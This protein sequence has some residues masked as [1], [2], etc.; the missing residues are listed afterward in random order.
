MIRPW[1]KRLRD[2]VG[3]DAAART[4]QEAERRFREI[5]EHAPIGM[6]VTTL[7]GQ[8]VQVN[9]AACQM[10]GYH[11]DELLGRS[12]VDV[13]H[14]DDVPRT[15]RGLAA[16][17]L[18]EGGTLAYD[19][20]YVHRDGRTLWVSVNAAVMRDE[21]GRAAF[22]VG[23]IKDITERVELEHR[24]EAQRAELER[25]NEELAQFASVASHDLREPLRVIAGYLDLLVRRFGDALDEEARELVRE[26]VGGAERM[27]ELIDG[28][29]RYS[30]VGRAQAE[31]REV[32]VAE[33]LDGTLQG[34]QA[35]LRDAEA[36]VEVDE[37][38]PI[39]QADPALL[40]QLFQ[41]LLA[42]AVKFRNGSP[43]RVRV[44]GETLA[45][46]WRFVVEDNGIGVPPEAAERI[47]DMFSRATTRDRYEGT[48][49]GLAVC[50][51]IV[52]RHNGTIGVEPVADGPGSRF[53]FTIP[54][55]GPDAAAPR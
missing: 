40:G 22:V 50:R 26:A 16:F 48:G 49:I 51:R 36:T 29:L 39:V 45:D 30:G 46:G 38:L 4:L 47:F 27:G 21:D 28:L 20:R 15:L 31:R 41:N 54:A 33:I 12:V 25:S 55:V 5:F 10:L 24:I 32:D 9:P 34:L 2:P 37:D 23:Q 35:A 53:I 44:S 3:D 18:D 1:R 6:V 19:K 52:E 17:E 42:N 13:T 14:P 7:A 8:F 11:R 43:P